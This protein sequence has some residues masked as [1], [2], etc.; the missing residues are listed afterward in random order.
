M[1]SAGASKH[2][3]GIG[4]TRWPRAR[5]DVFDPFRSGVSVAVAV[6]KRV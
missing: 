4:S 6:E 1:T 5:D 3:L 2:V